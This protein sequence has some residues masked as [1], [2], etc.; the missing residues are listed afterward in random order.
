MMLREQIFKLL[1]LFKMKQ[2]AG[3]C[4]FRLFYEQLHEI[5]F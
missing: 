4:V 5:N 2:K 1:N 3:T